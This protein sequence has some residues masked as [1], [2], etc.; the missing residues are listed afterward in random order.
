MKST[1][2]KYLCSK[3]DQT[4]TGCTNV[5]IVS[6]SDIYITMSPIERDLLEESNFYESKI[7]DSGI[8]IFAK[9]CYSNIDQ[10]YA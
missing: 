9:K 7:M 10:Y 8:D 4:N 2:K 1:L 6:Q 5:Q 3:Y